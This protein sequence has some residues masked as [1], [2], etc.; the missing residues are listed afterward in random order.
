VTS[1]SDA[2]EADP[3][4]H[5]LST[6]LFSLTLKGVVSSSLSGRGGAYQDVIRLYVSVHYVC[7]PEQTQGQKK[8]VGISTDS[9]DVEANVFSK[10]FDNVAKIHTKWWDQTSTETNG[11][12]RTSLID[13]NT[14]QR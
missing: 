5:N 12:G 13:S 11:L 6:V 1:F 9:A 7:F 4:S 14:R 10:S 3:R 2:S 8:L